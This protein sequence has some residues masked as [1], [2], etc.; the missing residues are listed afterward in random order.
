M[1]VDSHS[2][3]TL[4]GIVN[5]IYGVLI[6]ALSTHYLSPEDYG[7]YFYVLSL[8]M[9]ARISLLPGFEKTIPGYSSKNR[10][11]IVNGVNFLSAKHGVV[12]LCLLISYALIFEN[13][14][15]TRLMLILGSVLFTPYYL[16]QR[17]FQIM[18]G[19][20]KFYEIFKLRVAISLI[21]IVV[22]Y[23]SL[24][25]LHVNIVQ[26][27]SIN[28][29]TTIILNFLAYRYYVLQ[30][31]QVDKIISSEVKK[32]FD[33]G[34][35]IT[36]AGIPAM[37]LDPLLVIFIGNFIGMK[38]VSVFVIAKNIIGAGGNIIKSMM[39]PITVHYYKV[40]K[41]LFI[42]KEVVILLL[43][44][45]IL[46]LLALLIS[47]YLLP[48][49]LGLKYSDSMQLVYILLIGFIVEPLGILLHQNILFNS[50]VKEYAVALN[51]VLLVK[52]VLYVVITPYFGIL[53]VVYV[54]IVM[55]YFYV[56][57]NAYL[58]Y[59]RNFKNQS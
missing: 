19:E 25:I 54:N 59:N 27:F 57:M 14:D 49:L 37:V 40:N 21:L 34:K 58:L 6:L 15:E 45:F 26:Y 29:L 30:I 24:A 39:R 4:A 2:Y 55:V 5:A 9:L 18:V 35:G 8:M 53:G 52:L 44:G 33:S 41:N 1:T 16:F 11:D 31:R 36:I 20:E 56:V 17:V 28:I 48:Y 23:F 42:F 43:F 47:S 13:N 10:T 46:Y 12:G 3:S 7:N 32:A 51:T 22:N 38:E 50:Y